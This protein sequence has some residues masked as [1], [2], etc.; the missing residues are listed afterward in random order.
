[1]AEMTL[2]R[3]PFSEAL[4]S[5]GNNP[6]ATRHDSTIDLVDDYGLATTW[7]VTSFRSNNGRCVLLQRVSATGQTLREVLPS[8]VVAAIE[9]HGVS[10]VKV[11]RRRGAQQAVATKRAAGL[12]VGNP[13]ALAKA[14][15]ARKAGG[16]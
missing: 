3:D 13:E 16:R 4:R 7:V 14:R 9:R 10:A 11:S 5:F 8:E 2:P 6:G 15:K 12:P 1:M